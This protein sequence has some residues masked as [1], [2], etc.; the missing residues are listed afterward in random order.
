MSQRFEIVATTSGVPA[1]RDCATGEVMHPVVGPRREA[2]DLYIAPSR[3]TRRLES[4][5]REPLILFDIGLGAGG[6]AIAAW[7]ASEMRQEGGRRL[8]IV[9]FDETTEALKLAIGGG[10]AFGF[11]GDSARAA[12][13]FLER[14]LVESS[15]TSW[16]L[17][18]GTL[19]AALA[20]PELGAAD[21]VFWDPFSPRQNPSLWS[22]AAFAALRERCRAGCTLHTYSTA[23]AV[24]AA[25]LL[26]D[27]AVGAGPPSG[28]KEE[29]TIAALSET[30]L[31]RPLDR[32]WLERL[33][34]SSA[35]LPPDA[36]AD[37]IERIAG[38]AQFAL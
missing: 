32:R 7:N 12:R 29:T 22:V 28:S 10:E 5:E 8:E 13:T 25:L 16:R 30:D 14:G 9:S 27:F 2:E 4:E 6:N 24:R 19:P 33:R 26:A 18:F 15:R 35:P 31:A 20:A 1:V 21:V 17:V 38:R 3:L 34:R 23:T 11:Q 36:P 37:A